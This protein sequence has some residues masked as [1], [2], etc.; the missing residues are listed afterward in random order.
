MAGEGASSTATKAAKV[1][2]KVPGEGQKASSN[3]GRWRPS[4]MTQTEIGALRKRGYLPSTDVATT[5]SPVVEDPMGELN[6]VQVLEPC[7]GE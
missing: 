5:C 4:I 1:G 2:K 7:S 6:S 3:R